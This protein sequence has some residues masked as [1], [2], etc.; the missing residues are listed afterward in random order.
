MRIGS[1]RVYRLSQ[2]LCEPYHLSYRT[3]SA[4]DSVWVKLELTDGN[5]GWG[6]ST[7]LPGYT[8]SDLSA[9][10]ATTNNLAR[11]WIGKDANSIL[12]SPPCAQ[13]GFLFTAIWTALEEATGGIPQLTGKV[14][15]VGLVQER[16][17]E[18]PEN[19]LQRVRKLSYKAFKI[20]VGFLSSD[21]DRKRLRTFQHGLH[22]GEYIRVDANQSL[23]EASARMLLSSC[24]PGKIEL[25]EQPL[26]VKAWDE[27]ARLARLAPVPIMLD[28][29]ITDLE[30][31]DR[32]AR[33]G[34]AKIIKLKWMKQGGMSFL[35][36]MVE[37]ARR[38]DLRIVL[39]N[40]VAGWIDNRHEAIFWLE[41]LQDMQLAG[42]MNG[43]LKIKDDTTLLGFT[44]GCLNFSLKKAKEIDPMRYKPSVIRTYRI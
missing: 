38:L 28:E 34:A 7:P 41:Q 6:E 10:W 19:A 16:A 25:F 31:L 17:G 12:V 32:T 26:P 5:M 8:E 23:S 18:S 24:I 15:L 30:S 21:E 3:I 11:A 42:E 22:D 4:L 40:G 14:P 1:I 2:P 29:S 43:Y 27:C 39:G 9:V 36:A 13:D 44:D 20:K 37:R 35:R 33:S